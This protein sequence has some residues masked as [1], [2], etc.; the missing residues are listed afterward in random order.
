MNP[1]QFT[2][3]AVNIGYSYWS[4]DGHHRHHGVPGPSPRWH[5]AS[6]MHGQTGHGVPGRVRHH[7]HATGDPV[8]GRNEGKRKRLVSVFGAPQCHSGRFS[9]SSLT[10]R[11]VGPTT[12][13]SHHPAL[14]GAPILAR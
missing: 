4:S 10:L 11:P 7:R 3:W 13:L 8:P 12:H 5:V 1:I 6:A 9:N 2:V 14:C